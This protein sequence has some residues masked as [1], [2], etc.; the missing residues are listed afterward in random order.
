MPPEPIGLKPL[1]G[2]K[3]SKIFEAF[4][5]VRLR[6]KLLQSAVLLSLS[7]GRLRLNPFSTLQKLSAS[8]CPAEDG[9]DG[10]AERGGGQAPLGAEA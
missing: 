10:C 2:L 5:G 6:R 4:T 8:C 9:R 1:L 7:V 3:S